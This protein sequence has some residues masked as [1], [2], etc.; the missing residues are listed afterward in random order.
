MNYLANILLDT[1]GVEKN[2]YMNFL[3]DLYKRYPV[4][5]TNT[6]KNSE[7]KYN[8]YE[9]IPED[10]KIYEYMQYNNM[11]DDEKIKELYENEKNE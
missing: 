8:N 7:G 4:I 11:F 10:F 9:E 1:A 2:K 5:T 6:Y 3:E